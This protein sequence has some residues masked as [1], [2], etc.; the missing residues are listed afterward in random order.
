MKNEAASGTISR[1][2]VNTVEMAVVMSARSRRLS[3]DTPR[4]LTPR[5]TSTHGRRNGPTRA[6]MGLP[7]PGY[8]ANSVAGTAT[9]ATRTHVAMTPYS[10]DDPPLFAVIPFNRTDLAGTPWPTGCRV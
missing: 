7:Q 10:M 4:T 8:R 3:R 2:S 6:G 9:K 5:A 1:A